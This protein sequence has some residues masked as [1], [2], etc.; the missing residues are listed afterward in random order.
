MSMSSVS[1]MW[2]AFSGGTPSSASVWR[3]IFG[4]GFSQPCSFENVSTP[5]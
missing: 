2:R 5:K 4:S 1:P 3:K